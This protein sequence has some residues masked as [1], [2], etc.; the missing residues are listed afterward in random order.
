MKI[1]KSLLC[2][3]IFILLI[4][5][6]IKLGE[7]YYRYYAFKAK[8]EDISRFE[9]QQEKIL[10]QV[11]AQA[12][13]LGIPITETDV[14]ISGTRGRYVIETGWTETVNLFDLY[15]KTYNFHIEVGK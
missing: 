13:E 8:L 7:P 9:D 5:S 12:Q 11:I 2:L 4:Y 3:G 10:P 15:K 6:G 1:L 14:S